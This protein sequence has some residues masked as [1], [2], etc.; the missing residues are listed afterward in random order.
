MGHNFISDA[1]TIPLLLLYFSVFKLL[2]LAYADPP[3]KFCS[4]TSLYAANSPFEN[5]LQTLM[6]Y[7]ASN[8]SVSK[9][10][11]AYAGNDSDIIYAQYMCYNYITNVNCS[12]CIDAASQH[13]MQLCPNKT[14]ATVWEELCQLRFSNKK[15]IGELDFS[16]NIPLSNRKVIENSS[17]YVS[18]LN[19]YFS[20]LSKKAAFDPTQNMYATGKLALPDLDTLYALGKCT[21]DLSSHD[22][23]TCLQVAIQ[24]ISSC[25]FISRGARLLSRSCY[26]RYELYAFY[27][28]SSELEIQRG[29]T[30]T[31]LKIVLGTCIPIA[32]L[33]ASCIIYF[34]RIRRKKTDEE[35]NHLSFFQELRKSRGSTFA[36]GNKLSSEDSWTTWRQSLAISLNLLDHA[37]ADPPYRACS[38]ISASS[39]FQNNLQNLTSS[40]RSNASVSKLYN[41]SSGNDLD[42]IYA[43]Y[44]CLNY[45]T[46]D[47]CSTCIKR[48]SEDIMQ[49][50]PEDKEAIV[51]EEI[52]QLR[53]SNQSFLGHLDVSGNDPLDNKKDFENPEQFRLVVNE[54]LND[55]TTQ[56]AFNAS[57]NMYATRKA[58]F[59]NTDT[60]YALMQCSTDL[61]PGDCNT[62]LRVAM[63]NISSC[64]SA[65]RGGRVL[66][67]SCYLRYE[68]YAWYEGANETSQSPPVPAKSNHRKI[69]IIIILTVAAALLVVG[70]LGSLIYCHAMRN[71]RE[72]QNTR[73]DR[74]CGGI[75]HPNH[76]DYHL[77]NLPRDGV[78]DGESAF[79]DLETINAATGNFS[80]SNLLGQGGFGPVYK[81]GKKISGS[82]KSFQLLLLCFS[83]SNF[84]DLADADPPYKSCSNNSSY[85]D[86]SPFKNNLEIIMSYLRSNASVSKIYNTSTGNDLDRIYAHYMCLNYATHDECSTCIKVASQTITRL[87]PGDKEAVVWEE[88]CQLRYSSQNF[89][90][91]LDVSRNIPQY[92]KKDVKNPAQFRLVVNETLD[93]LIE[94]ASFNASANMYSTRQ[95]TT[96]TYTLYA[97]AQC[98]TDL[99]PYDCNKCLQVSRANIS[100]CCDA[101]SGVRVLSRSCYLWYEFYSFYEGETNS[102]EKGK[103]FCMLS[104]SAPKVADVFLKHYKLTMTSLP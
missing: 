55:L 25:C 12:S 18:V 9:Q 11:H 1:K 67:R 85:S 89:S 17:Q 29:R 14:D 4:N 15:F 94:Q 59:T 98:S 19:E 54:T 81:M 70:I 6:S 8:A 24:N 40:L 53:Y 56:V 27:E 3:Y 73:I 33:T 99:S 42:R 103:C 37:H 38:N 46:H 13:I 35:K 78:N 28:G 63:A 96:D 95:V 74:T 64:C 102:A 34:R 93:N 32:V 60:L 62:C 20:N 90:A 39:Q 79:M 75:G 77:P 66:S 21:T 92:K 80:E 23:N 82:S 83:L 87:C 84:L 2:N 61:S 58:A 97:L 44:M 48:A 50:C 49:L 31:I 101:S 88:P 22:C 10:Y 7:L 68:L 76:D 47:E 72:K 71:E 100:S 45:V 36:E 5:N 16:G 52:C 104:I 86:N 41:T 26:F 65:S 69:W 51:W 91:H 30:W 57:T 43:Q